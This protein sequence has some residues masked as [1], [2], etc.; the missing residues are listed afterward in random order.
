[1][2]NNLFLVAALTAAAVFFTGTVATRAAAFGTGS[3]I[4]PAGTCAADG[5]RRAAHLSNCKA[6]N[7]RMKQKTKK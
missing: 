4:C 3:G 1:M 2:K 7:C 6:S 5:G